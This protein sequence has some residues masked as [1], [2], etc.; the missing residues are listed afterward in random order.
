MV[1][2]LI[3]PF[4]LN[5]SVM[6]AFCDY[7]VQIPVVA[8]LVGGKQISKGALEVLLDVL[9]LLLYLRVDMTKPGLVGWASGLRGTPC[10]TCTALEAHTLCSHKAII[11]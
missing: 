9:L 2:L 6:L 7:D 10:T 5:V 1:T 3:E 8:R 11:G 4:I